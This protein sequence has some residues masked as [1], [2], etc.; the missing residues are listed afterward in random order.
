MPDS[1][2]SCKQWRADLEA[3]LARGPAKNLTVLSYA[4]EA[5]TQLNFPVEWVVHYGEGRIY[6]S[7]YGHHWHN[8]TESPAGMRCAAFQTLLHRAIYW[9]A[10]RE[11]PGTIPN[12]FPGTEKISLN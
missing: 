11:V 8:Q 7:T 9:L 5:K 10:K 1:K 6:T 2:A 4:K 12:N 3:P